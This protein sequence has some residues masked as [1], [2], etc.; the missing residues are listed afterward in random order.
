VGSSGNRPKKC[1][2]RFRIGLYRTFLARQIFPQH[3]KGVARS[4][5]QDVNQFA[6][7]QL[8]TTVLPRR[9][10][11]ALPL[12]PKTP[13]NIAQSLEQ[14]ETR[15]QRGVWRCFVVGWEA[16]LDK[17]DEVVPSMSPKTW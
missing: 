12:S 15:V 1:T 16:M 14:A 8:P 5:Q 2:P 10:E 17:F 3:R 4:S 13:R 11:I 6:I 7:C 9:L